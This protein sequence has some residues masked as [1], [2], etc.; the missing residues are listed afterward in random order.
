MHRYI[1][2]FALSCAFVAVVGCSPAEVQPP[3]E[4]IPNIPPPR[5]ADAGPAAGGEGGAA[6]PAGR[7]PA[8]PK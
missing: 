8:M 3:P 4:S 7:T 1:L 6:V 2:S 5:G